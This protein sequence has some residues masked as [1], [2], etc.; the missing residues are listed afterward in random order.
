MQ[1]CRR[2]AA[3]A[4]LAEHARAIGDAYAA[5]RQ[6]EPT[7]RFRWPQRGGVDLAEVA[8]HALRA[9]TEGHCA[10]CDGF[11]IDATGEEQ[12][13]HFRPKSLPAFYALVCEWTNL[14][15]C[16]S[17][18]NRAKLD[19]WDEALLRPDDAT[20]RAARYFLYDAASGRLEASPA[21]PVDDQHRARRTI[22]IL[23]LNRPGACS[24]RRRAWRERQREGVT[25]EVDGAYRFLE[26]LGAPA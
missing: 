8:Y 1:G 11:P 7:Y 25:V 5:R 17:A 2:G 9:M 20:F 23:D 3:P 10:Y 16:C 26:E 15:L 4:L 18:C 13:D 21:A 6:I 19:Q 12:I 22:E 24:A 14:F